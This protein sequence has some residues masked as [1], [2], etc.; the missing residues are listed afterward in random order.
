MMQKGCGMLSDKMSTRQLNGG[1][2]AKF[3]GLESSSVGQAVVKSQGDPILER[4]TKI[5]CIS[6]DKRMGK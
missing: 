6:G 5:P 3:G 2:K 4:E 1:G